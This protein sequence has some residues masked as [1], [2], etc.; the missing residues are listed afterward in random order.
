M[1]TFNSYVSLP[2]G[3]H[4]FHMLDFRFSPEILKMID[5]FSLPKNDIDLKDLAKRL[6]LV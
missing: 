5:V 1:A 6:L 3:Y 2:R 4:N